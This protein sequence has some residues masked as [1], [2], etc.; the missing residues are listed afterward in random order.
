MAS[1]AT[2]SNWSTPFVWKNGLRTEI[3]TAGT[4][5]VR[6]YDIDG[7]LL[8]ELEGMSIITIG[9]PFAQNGLLYISSGYVLDHEKNAVTLRTIRPGKRRDIVASRQTRC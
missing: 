1:N 7:K 5:R 8:W 3:V 6:S 2:N 4:K 9:T